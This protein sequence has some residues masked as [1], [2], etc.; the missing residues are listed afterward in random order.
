MAYNRVGCEP[1]SCMCA[2]LTLCIRSEVDVIGFLGDW[3]AAG[4][5]DCL[6][7]PTACF[8]SEDDKL[9]VVQC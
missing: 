1:A 2:T 6:H 4:T 7:S 8:S 3:L 5:H 9:I